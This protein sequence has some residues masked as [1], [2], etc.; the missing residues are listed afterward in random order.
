MSMHQHVRYLLLRSRFTPVHEMMDFA[1]SQLYLPTDRTTLLVNGVPLKHSSVST[2]YSSGIDEET[3]LSVVAKQ[4]VSLRCHHVNY[5]RYYK[6]DV[7]F[8]PGKPLG[9][10]WS[11]LQVCLVLV[12]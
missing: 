2:L 11:T 1:C 12:H 5:E 3:V 8:E 4:P 9:E 10:L 7:N 6:Q